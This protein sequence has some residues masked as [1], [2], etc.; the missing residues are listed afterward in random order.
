MESLIWQQRCRSATA[1]ASLRLF[2]Y[3]SRTDCLTSEFRFSEHQEFS[4][5]IF[6]S[7][8]FAQAGMKGVVTVSAV[9]PSGEALA[10]RRFQPLPDYGGEKPQHVAALL[11]LVLGLS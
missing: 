3:N 5:Q 9:A 1:A 8:Q 7:Q 11:R 10:D 4:R 2:Q 6:E